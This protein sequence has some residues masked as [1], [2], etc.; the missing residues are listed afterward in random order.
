MAHKRA[1]LRAIDQGTR[2]DITGNLRRLTRAIERGDYGKLDH[3]IIGLKGWDNF[4][5][6]RNHQRPT[7]TTLAF[8][9]S[10]MPQLAYTA[11]IM[12]KRMTGNTD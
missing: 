12:K 1:K 11:D 2:Y 4:D 9:S 6:E 10:E 5:Q 7:Y 3:V 8:G